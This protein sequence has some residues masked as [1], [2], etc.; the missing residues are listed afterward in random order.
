[1]KLCDNPFAIL[2]ASPRDSLHRLTEKAD[3]AALIGGVSVDNALSTLIQMNRRISAEL[4]WFPGASDD[5]VASFRTYADIVATG[6]HASLPPV[7]G[8][9]SSLAQANALA[10]FFEIW[11]LSHTEYLI[12]L[13]RSLSMILSKVTVAETLAAINADRQAGGWDIIPNEQIL[14]EPLGN[15]LRELTQIVRSGIEKAETEK[16]AAQVAK[17]LFVLPSFSAQGV[18]GDA[19]AEAYLMRI[20]DQEEKLRN[21]I[22]Q[23]SSVY[24]NEKVTQSQLDAMKSNLETWNQLTFPLRMRPGAFRRNATSLCHDMRE[25]IIN[26]FNNAEPK[27]INKSQVFPT[28][29]GTRTVTVTY[30]SKK[31]IALAMIGMTKWLAGL[32]PEQTDLVAM[33]KKDQDTL[34]DIIVQE[35]SSAMQA[36]IRGNN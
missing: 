27:N 12:G 35:D 17:K 26:C 22:T 7:L 29:N 13:C 10:A 5:A 6:Q 31:E 20:H 1:M 8:L 18:V 3:E 19:I 28:L 33:L 21:K 14:A 4:N 34:S 16:E 23:Q 36:L 30:K 11:P 25:C 2:E 32:F 24:K 15:R 9:G